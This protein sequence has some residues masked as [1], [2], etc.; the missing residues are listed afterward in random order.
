MRRSP[1]ALLLAALA[2]L[3]GCWASTAQLRQRAASDFDCPPE[4]LEVS[5]IGSGVYR[6]SGCARQDT[7]VFSDEAKAWLRESE[8]G[9][10]VKR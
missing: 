8:A 5:D 3:T 9:G 1:A 10:R 6:V 2:A 7:Y 4:K